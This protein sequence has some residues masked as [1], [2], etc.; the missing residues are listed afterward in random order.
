MFKFEVPHSVLISK[1]DLNS[2]AWPL[3]FCGTFCSTL[4]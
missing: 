4:R 2:A 1:L 3:R